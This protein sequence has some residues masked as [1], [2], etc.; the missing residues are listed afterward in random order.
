[1]LCLSR[2]RC[3]SMPN[4]H[5]TSA[6]SVSQTLHSIDPILMHALAHVHSI[7]LENCSAHNTVSHSRRRNCVSSPTASTS[8]VC[9]VSGESGAGKTETTKLLVQ[10]ILARCC[11]GVVTVAAG[12]GVSNGT[13]GQPLHEKVCCAQGDASVCVYFSSHWAHSA[14]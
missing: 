3:Y 13:F 5:H 6:L 7:C 12:G 1:V 11:G 2:T 4:G 9:V 8:Q 10:H 14:L